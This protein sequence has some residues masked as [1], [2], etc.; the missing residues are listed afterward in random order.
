MID[1]YQKQVFETRE[2]ICQVTHNDRLLQECNKI[3]K[4]EIS[5]FRKTTTALKRA[6]ITPKDLSTSKLWHL[7]CTSQPNLLL[8]QLKWLASDAIVSDLAMRL[9]K[10]NFT[11]EINLKRIRRDEQKYQR[12]LEKEASFME[13]STQMRFITFTNKMGDYMGSLS[14]TRAARLLGEAAHG[15]LR[16]LSDH[17][18]EISFWGNN[19]R[20]RPAASDYT[21]NVLLERVFNSVINAYIH[22]CA[23]KTE[24]SEFTQS[25]DLDLHFQA[26]M[27]FK[28]NFFNC[29]IGDW[30]EVRKLRMTGFC[31]QKTVD[32]LG[33]LMQGLNSRILKMEEELE[34]IHEESSAILM[35]AEK[36]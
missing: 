1:V 13:A 29:L 27:H 4:D 30:L 18:K 22:L 23:F 26:V 20:D 15:H 35:V 12:L 5:E 34:I 6:G 10:M 17:L 7:V 31:V 14:A 33:M 3:F 19:E 9:E 24:V 8:M 16:I 28:A 2:T 11:G 36:V 25:R 21:T 32:S